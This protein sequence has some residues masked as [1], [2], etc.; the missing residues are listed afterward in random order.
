MEV[1]WICPRLLNHGVIV[2]QSHPRSAS[3]IRCQLTQFR[4]KNQLFNLLARFPQ[5]DTLHEDVR[6]VTVSSA[7]IMIHIITLHKLRD[8]RVNSILP[9]R[10]LGTLQEV[11]NNQK[12]VF[13]VKFN[14]LARN[15][16]VNTMESLEA[17]LIRRLGAFSTQSLVFITHWRSSC[18][19]AFQ[20]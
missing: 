2:I 15:L 16:C 1:R 13:T 7:L 3:E 19:E 8:S 6:V 10:Q 12:P 5:I 9:Q 18:C 11:I 17:L 20:V 14:L 4:V